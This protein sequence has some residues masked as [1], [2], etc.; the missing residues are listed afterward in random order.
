MISSPS[1]RGYAAPVK[2]LK[3]CVSK[4]KRAVLLVPQL[5][6]TKLSRIQT[7]ILH[8]PKIGSFHDEVELGNLAVWG[9]V[10]CVHDEVEQ[11]N[12]AVCGVLLCVQ[13][14]VE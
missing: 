12:V 1:F 10:L 13:D 11:G 9:V 4:A 3:K 6:L 8:P 7:T 2:F 5:S 14:E